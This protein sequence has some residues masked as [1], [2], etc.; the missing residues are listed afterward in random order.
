MNEMPYDVWALRI[1]DAIRKAAGKGADPKG[2]REHP[3]LKQQLL[4]L[5]EEA[6]AIVGAIGRNVDDVEILGA[7]RYDSL[8]GFLDE[9]LKFDDF[10]LLEYRYKI[11]SKK[12][13]GLRF[14]VEKVA[15]GAKVVVH[16]FRDLIFWDVDEQGE[17]ILQE[18]VAFDLIEGEIIGWHHSNLSRVY[19]RCSTWQA[20]LRETLTLPFRHL[21]DAAFEP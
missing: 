4:E 3:D 5:A 1:N 2:G 18:P 16:Y 6:S 10:V 8:D 19:S 17:R 13:P 9:M 14:K 15:G 12:E 21:Y 11:P 7:D 20:A